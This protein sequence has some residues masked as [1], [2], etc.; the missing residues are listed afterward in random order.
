MRASHRSRAVIEVGN[1]RAEPGFMALCLF[2]EVAEIPNGFNNDEM[3]SMSHAH[4]W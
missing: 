1:L 2:H 4:A 3:D